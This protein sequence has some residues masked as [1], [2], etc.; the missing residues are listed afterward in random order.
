MRVV[1][2][3]TVTKTVCN[4]P[5]YCSAALYLK[6]QPLCGAD[7]DAPPGVVTLPAFLQ[8]WALEL[9]KV[10]P[11]T[12]FFRILKKPNAN[13]LTRADFVPLLQEVVDGHPGLEFL[14]ETPEF[15]QRYMQTV[16]ARIFYSV[17]KSGNERM[18][19]GELRKSTFME[20][21]A[22]LDEEDDINKIHDFFS[23]E[24]FYV[25]YVKFW[26]LDTDHN[27]LL[28]RED[29]L[30]YSDFALTSRCM[31]RVMAQVPRR[32]RGNTENKMGFEDFI[33]FMISEEDKSS[34]VAK[35][36]W[37]RV[38]D[39]D[40]DGELRRHE[41]EFFFR[42]QQQRM[43]HLAHESIL[44]D[45]IFCQLLDMVKPARPEVI[46]LADLL[47]CKLAPFFFNML[48]N[49]SK[50]I[51]HEQ[52]D[53]LAVEREKAYPHLSDW[54]RFAIGAYYLL[55]GEEEGGGGGGGGDE[56]QQQLQM[57]QQMQMQQHMQEQ[58]SELGFDATNGELDDEHEHEHGLDQDDE[59]QQHQHHQE[60]E[61]HHQQ[62]QQQQQQQ[63][64]QEAA[65]AAALHPDLDVTSPFDGSDPLAAVHLA[66]PSNSAMLMT[67]GGGGGAS[68][69][70]LH[71]PAASPPP[72]V[73]LQAEIDQ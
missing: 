22:L 17:N 42:E 35:E 49:L 39:L 64:A 73:T 11:V 50:F 2:F 45:D 31:D 47:R 71:S 41:L 58:G 34:D 12:R 70:M 48:L 43:Q 28:D 6:L 65:L 30:S 19:L 44:F 16:I 7:A 3:H 66:S 40:G 4:L 59:Y 36:Y 55:S 21:L 9:E 29:L 37:F 27:F 8:Y 68:S 32:F 60:L 63:F 24:H 25:L 33:V 62:Q 13:Y 38:L 67:S 1:D 69:M 18:T 5:S 72:A 54:D 20:V 53:A 15:Q 10:D 61:Q 56:A 52:R 14:E 51:R 46:T 23:Y 26:E 57:Q